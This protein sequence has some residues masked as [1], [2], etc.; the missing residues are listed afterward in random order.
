MVGGAI[1]VGALG[2]PR[3]VETDWAALPVLVWAATLTWIRCT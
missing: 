2:A 3:I 1:L